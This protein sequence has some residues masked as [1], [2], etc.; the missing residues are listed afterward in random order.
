MLIMCLSPPVMI[1]LDGFD[2]C[3]RRVDPAGLTGGDAEGTDPMALL[4]SNRALKQ[5]CCVVMSA[6]AACQ[7]LPQQ[8][9][10]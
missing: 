6:P 10:K 2:L 4:G 1:L 9:S 8:Y 7:H 3:H 5:Y